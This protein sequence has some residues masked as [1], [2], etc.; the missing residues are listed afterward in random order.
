MG[1]EYALAWV[2]GVV[3]SVNSGALPE[4]LPA[5]A[6]AEEALEGGVFIGVSSCILCSCQL[7]DIDHSR[8]AHT[9]FHA[10]P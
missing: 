2:H 5:S 8:E 7:R 6:S 9:S 4:V 1:S 10:A 3:A